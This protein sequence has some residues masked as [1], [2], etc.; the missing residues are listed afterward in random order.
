[1]YAVVYAYNRMESDEQLLPL[2]SH[3]SHPLPRGSLPLSKSSSPY[4]HHKP[5]MYPLSSQINH[6][7]KISFSTSAHLEEKNKRMNK[8]QTC[9]LTGERGKGRFGVS[10]SSSYYGFVINSL[11]ASRIGGA[12]L[13]Q[14]IQRQKSIRGRQTRQN[15][16]LRHHTV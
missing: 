10:S 12:L 15:G 7:L 16:L 14:V 4:F 9:E 2:S 3:V 5:V 1:M 6:E 13:W 8:V 11:I